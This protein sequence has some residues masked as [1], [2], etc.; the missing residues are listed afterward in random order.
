MTCVLIKRGS[1]CTETCVEG[2]QC[3]ETQGESGHLQAK[4]K[5]LEHI[6]PH[7]LQR[8][9]P[10]QYLDF[11]LL[12]SKTVGREISA[13]YATWCW[14]FV[15]ATLG[16]TNT[17]GCSAMNHYSQG[18]YNLVGGMY[19]TGLWSQAKEMQQILLKQIRKMMNL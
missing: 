9:Q 1:L 13:V 16:E 7:S 12:D 18:V 6:F 8:N 14:Y 10:Y 3:D 17:D 19:S 15:M 4:D 11:G 2:R 5:N